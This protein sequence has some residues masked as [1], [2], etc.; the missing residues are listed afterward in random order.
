[1]FTCPY[2]GK[3]LEY[4]TKFCDGCGK[5]VYEPIFC[6]YCGEKTT[7]E[8][9]VC[10]KCGAYPIQ[11]EEYNVKPEAMEPVVVKPKAEV[12]APPVVKP[13][14]KAEAKQPPVMPVSQAQESM[15]IYQIVSG[16]L[17]AAIA[18]CTFSKWF[19]V[20]LYDYKVLTF[21]V[22]D[23]LNASQNMYL[24]AIVGAS[25]TQREYGMVTGVI[26][27]AVAAVFSV[28]AAH[29][30]ALFAI[31]IQKRDAAT[32][33]QMAAVYSTIICIIAGLLCLC[34][35]GSTKFS[36]LGLSLSVTAQF[37]VVFALGLAVA[38]CASRF[39]D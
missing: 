4:G 23:L 29:A 39:D 2:C 13:E 33:S 1:M 8:F 28:A 16:F 14:N 5:R 20:S 37:V 38:C 34:V 30:Y 9:E 18:V 24:Q 26:F 36:Y 21:S 32:I 6:P 35:N 3:E 17:S 27:L 7:T 12:K 10:P 22:F 11:I 31:I 25:G 19:S 15:H